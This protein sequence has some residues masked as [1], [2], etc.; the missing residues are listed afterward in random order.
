MINKGLREGSD[1][2]GQKNP[3]MSRNSKRKWPDLVYIF[4]TI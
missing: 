3:C 2:D 4:V 1:A